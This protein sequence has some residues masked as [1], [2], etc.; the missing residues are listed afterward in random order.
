MSVIYL[1]WFFS[2]TLLSIALLGWT[3]LRVGSQSKDDV[4]LS[5]AVTYEAIGSI[6]FSITL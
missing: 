2:L 6:D 3:V 1:R 5:S 4:G